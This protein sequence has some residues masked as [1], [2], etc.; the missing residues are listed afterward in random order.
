M[1]SELSFLLRA[2][3]FTGFLAALYPFLVAPFALLPHTWAPN[4]RYPLN[5]TGHLR[6]RLIEVKHHPA[7]PIVFLGS[8]H[9]YRGFDPRIWERRGY[10]SFN[11]GSSSQSPIQ[12]EMVCRDLVPR[13]R[14]RLAIMEVHPNALQTDGIESALEFIANGPLNPGV[15]RMATRVPH[16]MVAN[17][18]AYGALR[19]ALGIDARIPEAVRKK[20]DTYVG[21]GYVERDMEHFS[22]SSKPAPQPRDCEPG[23]RQLQALERALRALYKQGLSVVLVEAPVTRWMREGIYRG[24]DRFAER[25]ARAGR[26]ID[27]N[28]KVALDDSLHFY[29]HSHLNQAGVELFNA[30]LIDTLRGRGWLPA[31]EA[32]RPASPGQAGQGE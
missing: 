13:L 1:R 29:D 8:S 21:R 14:P 16:A 20:L 24:H 22:P 12:T 17:A 11:L 2:L 28:G 5:D 31:P 19:K 23:E 7:A 30:A 25:M 10:G 32:L 26:Y 27:M 9:A 3:G 6:T 18:V 4:L 15:L